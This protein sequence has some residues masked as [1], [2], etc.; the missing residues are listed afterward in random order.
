VSEQPFRVEIDKLR[1]DTRTRVQALIQ[2][3]VP[4]VAPALAVSVWQAGAPWFEAYAGWVDPEVQTTPVGFRSLFDLASVSKIFTATALLR[5]ANDFKLDLDD[6][7][8]RTLP[9]FAANGPRGVDG[10]VDPLTWKPLPTPAGR[11]GWAV[12]PEGVTWRRVL[13]H[14]SGLAPW[15]MVFR[16]AGPTP[17][18]PDEPDPVSVAA[19]WEAALAAIGGYRFVA[20]PGEEFHYSDLGFMLAGMAVARRF[21]QP[22]PDAMQA[23]IRDRLGLDSVTYRPAATGRARDLNVPT[24]YD[25]RWRRRRCWG[26]VH[27]ENAAGLGGVAGHA[28]LFA[29]AHD[30]ARFGVAWLRGDPR[31]RLERFRRTAVTNQTKELDAARG[32]GWQVQPTD[33]LAPFSSE[34]YGHTG[35]TGTSLVVDPRRDLV[36]ALLTNRVYHGRDPQAIDRLRLDVHEV[37]ANA[38]D[39]GIG[40]SSSR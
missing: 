39:A 10:G 23:L 2:G 9:E 18:P 8:G 16:E 26:E 30:V 35:F 37:F 17:A 38:N 31:L 36:V 27:D 13:T 5:L 1:T 4:D 12:D 3:A 24:E 28:G 40:P 21:G 15:H 34:A 19:R 22:L 7:V 32:L 25:E 33:H 29:T 6:P 11:E 14:S 20:R